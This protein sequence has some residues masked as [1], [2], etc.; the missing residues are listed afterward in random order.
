VS[1]L[2][3]SPAEVISE[4]A[5]GA[6]TGPVA[7]PYRNVPLGGPRAMTVRRSL[8]QKARSLIGA[9]CFVD[10]YGP[11]DV[12]RTGGMV[13]PGHPHTCLQT[14][15]WLFTGEVEHR[16]TTGAHA[17]VRPGQVNLMT[18]G[19]GIAHSEYSTP[20]TTVLHG[21][22]L[23]IALPESERFADPGFAHYEPPLIDVAGARARARVFIGTLFGQASPVPVFS[24]L[25]GAEV[26]LAPG[27]SLDVPVEAGYEHGFLCDTGSLHV[28]GVRA[29]P[30]EIVYHPAG[31]EVITVRAGAAEPARMLILGGEPLRERIIMW[32][33]FI[34]RSHE[35][36]VA[37][38]EDWERQRAGQAPGRYG[39]FPATWEH[40]L[41]APDLPNVRLRPRS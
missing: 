34:G 24:P 26:T 1:N 39:V 17:F 13:V 8:P 38:R 9:W 6:D 40:T 4:R 32:W 36:V 2:D 3:Q 28:A 18:A 15:S 16:D 31:A 23:W 22:Q 25:A 7:L 19:S 20:A 35:E 11:D 5:A 33:N 14:V 10:H 27:Y 12:S 21:A 30:G 41:P 29:G 37:L